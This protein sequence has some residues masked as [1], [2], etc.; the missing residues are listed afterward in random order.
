MKTILGTPL[1]DDELIQPKRKPFLISLFY[2]LFKSK[3]PCKV[4]VIQPSCTK[5]IGDTMCRDKDSVLRSKISFKFRCEKA[6]NKF[7]SLICK[8]LSLSFTV[9]VLL[10]FIALV[11][12]EGFILVALIFNLYNDFYL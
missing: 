6:K 2:Y 4:C 7:K 5:L 3:D 8:T 12:L 11:L 10:L 1:I 9:F